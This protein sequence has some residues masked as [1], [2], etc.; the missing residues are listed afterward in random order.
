MALPESLNPILTRELVYTGIT[1]AKLVHLADAPASTVL[2][3]AVERRVLRV[4]GLMA[5]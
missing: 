5:G 3:R 2:A 1:R 4:S